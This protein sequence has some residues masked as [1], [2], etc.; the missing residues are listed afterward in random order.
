MTSRI[1]VTGGAGFIGS[2]VVRHLIEGTASEVANLDK[3]TYASNGL[4]KLRDIEQLVLANMK[5]IK[6]WSPLSKLKKLKHL[7]LDGCIIDH[8]SAISFFKALIDEVLGVV[9]LD[10]GLAFFTLFFIVLYPAAIVPEVHAYATQSI[11]SPGKISF[12]TFV[13]FFDILIR[14]FLFNGL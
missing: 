6:D 10:F 13:I 7:H 1:L 5:Y 3:L 9:N 4:E 8:N 2:A 12:V 14:F 11:F